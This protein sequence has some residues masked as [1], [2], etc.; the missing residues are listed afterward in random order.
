MLGGVAPIQ[1]PQ[2]ATGLH[3]RKGF[4]Q[5][6]RRMRIQVVQDYADHGRLR[7]VHVYQLLHTIREILRGT[8]VG[9]LDVPPSLQGLKQHEQI[10]RALPAI[11]IIVPEQLTRYHWQGLARLADQLVRTLVNTDDRILWVLGLSVQA[12]KLC[13]A[14]DKFRAH[15]GHTPFLLLPW[16]AHVL[17]R[18]RRTVSS[19]IDSTMSSSTS[20]SARSCIVQHGR[21][22]GGALHARA[23]R[24]ASGLPANL[25]RPPGRGRSASAASRPSSTKRLRGRSTVAVPMWRACAM[26]SSGVPVC[27]WSRMCARFT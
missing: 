3:R 26:T 24:K 5:S 10:T 20:V 18:V 17:F 2:Q 27:A 4:V 13:H 15:C 12:E 11:L 23:I 9:D 8:P 21:S 22:S 25:R 19:E 6:S 1:L 14:P 7:E 16:L